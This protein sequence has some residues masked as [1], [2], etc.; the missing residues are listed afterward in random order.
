MLIGFGYTAGVGK[1]T[2]CDYLSEKHGWI[3]RSFADNLKKCS[4][5]VFN[6]PIE[7]FYDQEL[8]KKKLDRPIPF[9]L[10][11][12]SSIISWMNKS[13][14]GLCIPIN[15]EVYKEHMY[16]VFCTPRDILQFVGTEI[17]RTHCS[18]YH[19]ITCLNGIDVN[20]NYAIC[21]IRF[22]NEGEAILERGGVCVE[23]VSDSFLFGDNKKHASEVAMENWGRWAF[24]LVNK[25][26]E[27]FDVLYGK[28]DK[29]LE[30]IKNVKG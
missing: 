25:K 16:K 26:E 30:D 27:G 11:Y 8:K 7:F 5:S 1:D 18:N 19:I 28:I 3:K 24:R 4:S 14:D 6:L 13:V 12:F 2:V 10:Y 23:V 9:N 15:Y 17:M 22:P 21:D 29:L 20:T